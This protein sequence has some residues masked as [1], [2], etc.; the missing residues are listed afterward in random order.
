MP[1]RLEYSGNVLLSD[2]SDFDA[3]GS[4]AALANLIIK[5]CAEY[6][7][8]DVTKTLTDRFPQTPNDST[9]SL[10]VASA[11]YYNKTGSNKRG[12]SHSYEELVGCCGSMLTHNK[13]TDW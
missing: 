8:D 1:R 9:F 12:Y 7:R 3:N 5:C 6:S 4:T 13:P 11:I 2:I 10:A